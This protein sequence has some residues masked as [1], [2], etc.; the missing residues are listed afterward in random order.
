MRAVAQKLGIGTTETDRNGFHVV[1]TDAYRPV[2]QQAP[3]PTPVK[4]RERARGSNPF[5]ALL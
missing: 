1:R 5:H 3:E 4:R 2:S